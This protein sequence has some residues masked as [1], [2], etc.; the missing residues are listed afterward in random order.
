MDAT[1]RPNALVIRTLTSAVFPA[2][3]IRFIA[4]RVNP[5][6]PELMLTRV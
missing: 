1:R 5:L 4:V 3:A 6:T 2:V